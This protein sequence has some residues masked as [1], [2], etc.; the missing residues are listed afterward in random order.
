MYWDL[1]G[2]AVNKTIYSCHLSTHKLRGITSYGLLE[3]KDS[4]RMNIPKRSVY[5][6]VKHQT[7]Y[8]E[9]FH[10][11]PICLRY[12][13]KGTFQ[14]IDCIVLFFYLCR[15]CKY[16]LHWDF[17]ALYKET[18]KLQ[19]YYHKARL[20]AGFYQSYNQQH[21]LLS[22]YKEFKAYNLKF[23]NFHFMAMNS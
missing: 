10:R 19:V 5:S 2:T 3:R 21:A 8:N 7:D 17:V 23:F 4:P 1:K 14:T 9:Y 16:N 15:C 12:V 13:T 6:V 18:H 22:I 11:H 20:K